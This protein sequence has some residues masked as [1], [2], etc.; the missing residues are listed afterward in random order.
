MRIPPKQRSKL[1]DENCPDAYRGQNSRKPVM[2]IEQEL[3]LNK[4]ERNVS[5]TTTKRTVF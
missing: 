3:K 4:G 2:Q 5:N 1:R